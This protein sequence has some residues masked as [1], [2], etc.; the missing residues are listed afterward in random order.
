MKLEFEVKRANCGMT[1]GS[2]EVYCN[3]ACIVNFGDDKTLIGREWKSPKTDADFIIGALFHPYPE[4]EKHEE[5]IKEIIRKSMGERVIRVRQVGEIKERYRRYYYSVA[6]EQ[7]Y[8]VTEDFRGTRS[9]RTT[10]RNGGEP[11]CPLKDGLVFEIVKDGRVLRRE[12]IFRAD[13]CTS[14]GVEV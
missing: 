10:D 1:R 12:R 14:I 4:I 5:K 7:F 13:E 2:A 3:G 11:D 9:W 6:A 8:A